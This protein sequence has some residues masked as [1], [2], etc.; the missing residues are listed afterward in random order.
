MAPKRVSHGQKGLFST[1]YDEA[2]NPENNTIVRSLIVFGVGVAFLHSSLGE[3]L[4][5]PM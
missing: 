3:I 4:L 2:T 5:P 1:I